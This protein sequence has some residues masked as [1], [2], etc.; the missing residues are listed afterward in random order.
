MTELANTERVISLAHQVSLKVPGG[1]INLAVERMFAVDCWDTIRNAL[2][3]DIPHNDFR[4]RLEH[5]CAQCDEKFAVPPAA[6]AWA[7]LAVARVEEYHRSNP[8]I[9]PVWSGPD[10]DG[11]PFRKTQQAI[12]EVLDSAERSITLI[13]YSVYRIPVIGNALIR[14]A[15]RG[16]A[17][18]VIVE[19]PDLL[20]LGNEYSTLAALGKDV[21]RCTSIYY[22]PKDARE[23]ADNGKPGILHVKCAIS[24]GQRVFLS[25]AN[26]TRQAFTI[27]MELGVLVTGGELPEK[28]ESRFS[29]LI[30]TGVLLPVPTKTART[31]FP[32]EVI[33]PNE[34]EKYVTCVP[35]FDLEAA[36]GAFGNS[37]AVEE[38]IPDQWAV[39]TDRRSLRPG[40]F[41]ARVVG[42]SM[43]PRIPDGAYCLFTSPVTGSRNGRILLVQHRD[44]ADP[45][46]GGS[47]TVKKYARPLQDASEDQG[48]AGRILLKPL[49]ADYQP[50][51]IENG[52]EDIRVIAE[53]VQVLGRSG[54][55]TH[56]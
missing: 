49:N 47:Y 33:E 34:S 25:S 55:E 38:L 43:E 12:L 54:N 14:A 51:V 2:A 28:I 56:W 39:L 37:C 15:E 32:F 7:L 13:S 42:K 50:I 48:R 5:F 52:V 40:M 27:N 22:W 41:V 6:A 36:A 46:N 45:E 44:I 16:V 20:D 19:T 9:E 4:G 24:D 23:C 21:Q 1:V 3:N 35:L 31:G 8:R 11:I 26:L 29:A 30:E 10:P 53:L 18:R 17:I